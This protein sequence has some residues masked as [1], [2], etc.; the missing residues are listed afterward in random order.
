MEWL[1]LFDIN[2]N[3]INKKIIRGFTPDQ[4]EYIMIVYLFI[5][6]KQGS[7]LLEQ[8][9]D[10]NT[11]VIPG[12]H[13]DTDNP[14]DNIKREMKEELGI[15]IDKYT[16]HNIKTLVKKNRLFKL[17]YIKEDIDINDMVI[18]NEEVK[19]I[20]YYSI[21]EIDSMINNKIFKENNIMFIDA[22][23]EFLNEK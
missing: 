10:S 15:N 21:N 11:W 4:G 17:F 8:D 7:I 16:I 22:Y 5:I 12:G 9:S 1:Q 2:E 3:P 18:D 23:K 19:D 14:I 20:K 6:N 13:V